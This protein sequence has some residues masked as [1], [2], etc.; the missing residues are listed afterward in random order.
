MGEM[1]LCIMSERVVLCYLYAM[2]CWVGLVANKTNTTLN[3]YPYILG[4]VRYKYGL[5]VP[6]LR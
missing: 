3:R 6:V 1:T 4:R 5:V 2:L